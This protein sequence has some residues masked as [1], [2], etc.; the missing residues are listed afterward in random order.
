[1]SAHSSES[2][3]MV[4]KT[5]VCCWPR[6][7]FRDTISLN[8]K[9][10]LEAPKHRG[11]VLGR[12]LCF[13]FQ[14]LPGAGRKH[15]PRLLSMSQLFSSPFLNPCILWIF[16]V[17]LLLSLGWSLLSYISVYGCFA[18]ICVYS[19][20]TEARRGVRSPGGR[21][22]AF[23]IEPSRQYMK[24]VLDSEFLLISS[25]RGSLT[26]NLCANFSLVYKRNPRLGFELWGRVLI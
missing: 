12:S 10:G 9:R 20:P 11:L 23:T 8:P 17:H 18:C 4:Y 6:Q 2:Q 15:A 14:K 3:S 1:M 26:R 13:I 19:P 21:V 24:Y 25:H 5:P 16:K 7:S 22:N